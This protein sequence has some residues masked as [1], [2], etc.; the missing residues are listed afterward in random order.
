MIHN[1]MKPGLGIA[2]GTG[3]AVIV[4]KVIV[5]ASDSII[6]LKKTAI[7]APKYGAKVGR[8]GLNSKI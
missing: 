6:P 7:P 1:Y 2:I 4:L 3:I 8:H 5:V